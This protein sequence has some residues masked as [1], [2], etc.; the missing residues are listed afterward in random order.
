MKYSK[1]RKLAISAAQ[2]AGKI[3]LKYYDNHYEINQKDNDSPVTTADLEADIYLR[4]TILAEFPDDGWLSEETADSTERL[5][6]KRVW[7]VDP[8]DGTIEFIHGHAEFVVSVALTENS[9][10]VVGVVYNPLTRELFTAMAGDISRLNGA[11]IQC[12]TKTELSKS[13]VYV[14]RSETKSGKW[15]RYDGIFKLRF[16]SGSIAYKLVHTAACHSDMTISLH[17]KNEWD[18]CAADLIIRN[19]GGR[20]INRNLETVCY[21]SS[22][23]FIPNGLIAGPHHLVEK[24]IPIFQK[25]T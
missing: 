9:E 15:D 25:I 6:K 1:E 8:L 11:P 16:V 2:E 7:V 3:L 5:T 24:A 23:P 20:L 4:N 17:P 18:I 14:S 12:S 22:D 19:A 21:N 13:T 10:P